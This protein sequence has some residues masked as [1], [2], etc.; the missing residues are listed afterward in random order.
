LMIMKNNDCNKKIIY[1]MGKR[2]EDIMISRKKWEKKMRGHSSMR[3][4]EYSTIRT[5]AQEDL[6]YKILSSSKD[7]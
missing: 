4:I 7:F 6:Y 1:E 2:R 3:L 5:Y